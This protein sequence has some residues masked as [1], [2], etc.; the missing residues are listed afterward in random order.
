MTS[1]HRARGIIVHCQSPGAFLLK[2]CR[3]SSVAYFLMPHNL[4]V[5]SPFAEEAIAS[6]WLQ[7]RDYD[8]LNAP[9]SWRYSGPQP[10]TKN[11]ELP[12]SRSPREE[13]G[14]RAT[15]PAQSSPG[16]R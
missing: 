1:S 4:R 10:H 14:H 15:V 5:R 3:G 6:G 12:R 11:P 13:A 7:P 2:E 9:M 8:L 16:R